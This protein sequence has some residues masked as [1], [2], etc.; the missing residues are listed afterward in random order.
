MTKGTQARLVRAARA[1]AKNAYAPFSKF[2]VGA[3]VLTSKGKVFSGCNVE[4]SSYG[5]T[6]CAERVA[7]FKAVSAGERSIEAIAVFAPVPQSK[8]RKRKSKIPSL[9][10]PCGA[11]LQVVNEFGDNP[12]IVLSNGRS[13]KTYRLRNLLSQGFRL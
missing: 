11:C 5:L 8:I 13:T 1:A 7:I 3:A 4:N 2:R 9:T 12:D 6:I 10:P